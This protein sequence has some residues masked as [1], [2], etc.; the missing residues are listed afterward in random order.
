M[1]TEQ[2]YKVCLQKVFNEDA[3]TVEEYVELD[4]TLRGILQDQ[5]RLTESEAEI[6]LENARK[7]T[8]AIASYETADIATTQMDNAEK[9]LGD[10]K[11]KIPVLRDEVFFVSPTIIP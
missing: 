11:L 9:L 1:G 6:V 8:V 5:F 4:F 10:T 7:G 3:L 2:K